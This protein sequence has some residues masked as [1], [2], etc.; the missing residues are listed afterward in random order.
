MTS[1]DDTER[2]KID[3][4]KAKTMYDMVDYIDDGKRQVLYLSAEQAKLIASSKPGLERMLATL[5]LFPR[6]DDGPKPKLVLNLLKSLGLSNQFNDFKFGPAYFWQVAEE[7]PGKDR[8]KISS[9]DLALEKALAGGAREF[10]PESWTFVVNSED[11]KSTRVEWHSFVEVPKSMFE[12]DKLQ[13]IES[14]FTSAAEMEHIYFE[15]KPTLNNS[16][17]LAPF[18][19]EEQERLAEEKLDAFMAQVVIPL[20]ARTHAIVIVSPYDCMCCLARSFYR[21]VNLQRMR[22]GGH[23]PFSVVNV[24]GQIHELYFNGSADAEWRKV[25]R[26]SKNWTARD[27]EIKRIWSTRETRSPWRGVLEVDGDYL[28]NHLSHSMSHDL[29]TAATT[30]IVVDGLKE[31]GNCDAS[32]GAADELEMQLTRY[33]SVALPSLAIQTGSGWYMETT[34]DLVQARTQLMLLDLR[35]RPNLFSPDGTRAQLFDAAIKHQT[36]LDALLNLNPNP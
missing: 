18:A 35:E 25:R 6:A 3:E 15:P 11:T 19:V 28:P 32:V 10:D 20:A 1:I 9:N 36:A 27:K 4:I 16:K 13:E 21:M 12:A 17:G 30:Y 7:K 2:I 34:L 8:P 31:D 14:E 24:T 22:W 5:E 26:H 29:N 33:L 23:L